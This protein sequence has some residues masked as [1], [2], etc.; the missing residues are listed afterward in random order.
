MVGWNLW[1]G[2]VYPGM[3]KDSGGCPESMPTPKFPL[4]FISGPYVG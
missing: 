4:V 1:V 2:S 3:D